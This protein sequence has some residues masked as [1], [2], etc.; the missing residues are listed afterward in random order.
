MSEL[1]YVAIRVNPEIIAR[2][3][4]RNA[5][6]DFS[7]DDLLVAV[8]TLRTNSLTSHSSDLGLIS[9]LR[10]SLQYIYM[11]QGIT[12]AVTV[13]VDG[14]MLG[15]LRISFPGV[16]SYYALAE[17]LGFISNHYIRS[18]YN[19]IKAAEHGRAFARGWDSSIP[20]DPNSVAIP[21]D[22]SDLLIASVTVSNVYAPRRPDWRENMLVDDF[23][24]YNDENST[25]Q[26]RGLAQYVAA[27]EAV[28]TTAGY[29]RPAI[30]GIVGEDDDFIENIDS[31]EEAD[32]EDDADSEDED[33]DEGPTG[34]PVFMSDDGQPVMNGLPMQGQPVHIPTTPVWRRDIIQEI[35]V[36]QIAAPTVR[37]VF[38]TPTTFRDLVATAPATGRMGGGFL[39][40]TTQQPTNNENG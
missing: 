27:P 26:E 33:G 4:S 22:N 15:E 37:N 38:A 20:D 23:A 29:G 5:L 40:E 21:P 36:P 30:A 34:M 13:S 39:P 18:A 31:E 6:Q 12:K 17:A 2:L 32:G 1:A 24:V 28:V 3:A 25:D 8:P 7:S 16:Y 10:L 9:S 19:P 11:Y 14:A 35:T